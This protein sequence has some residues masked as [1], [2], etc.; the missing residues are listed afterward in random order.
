M[1]VKCG[2]SCILPDARSRIAETMTAPVFSS[3]RF[4]QTWLY[5]VS[6]GQLLFWSTKSKDVNTRIEILFKAVSLMLIPRSFR[7]LTITISDPSN[8]TAYG[9]ERFDLRGRS[10]YA[11]KSEDF[12]G[13]VVAGSITTHEDEFEYWV[14]SVLLQGCRLEHGRPILVRP[15]PGTP[16]MQHTCDDSQN[17]SG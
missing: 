16:H 5:T 1:H 13:F 15:V 8:L 17:S 6:H 14:P 3:D 7:G 9:I 4:F 11:L 12:K 10:L 2:T